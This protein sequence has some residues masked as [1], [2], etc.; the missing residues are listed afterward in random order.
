MPVP[1]LVHSPNPSSLLSFPSMQP[2]SSWINHMVLPN[3]LYIDRMMPR[4]PGQILSCPRIFWYH[5]FRP[6]LTNI[7]LMSVS[8]RWNIFFEEVQQ[9]TNPPFSALCETRDEPSDRRC[10]LATSRP[11]ANLTICLLRTNL[12]N[13]VVNDESREQENHLSVPASD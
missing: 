13:S 8:V 12:C 9:L 5:V 2:T 10:Q 11:K 6:A 4:C 7:T 1:T 3:V